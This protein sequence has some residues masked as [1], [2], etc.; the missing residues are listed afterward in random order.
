MVKRFLS[1]TLKVIFSMSLMNTASAATKSISTKYKLDEIFE[2]P[3]ILGASVS[4]D[5]RTDSPGKRLAL[6]YTSA[7]KIRTIAMNGQEGRDT[8]KQ[9]NLRALKDRTIVVGIDLFFWDSTKANPQESTKALQHLLS[10]VK[11][12]NI[13][14]VLGDIPTLMPQYQPSL[15]KLNQELQE[16][17]RS[18]EKCHLLPLNQILQKTIT[19]GYLVHQGHKYHLEELIPDGLHLVKPASEYLADQIAKLFER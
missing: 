7:D 15:A 13:P 9:V 8:L 6:R 19:D 11:E 18:Y 16:A 10:Q 4:A 5:Y 2:R 12:K 17:C 14:I 3:L 1:N